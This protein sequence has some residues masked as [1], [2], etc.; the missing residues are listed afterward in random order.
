[1]RRVRKRR[2]RR[3]RVQVGAPDESLTRFSGLIAVTELVERLDVIGRLDAA[4]GSLKQRR[5]GHTAQWP[6]V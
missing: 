1:V 3:A 5:R 2:A 6:C 4:I